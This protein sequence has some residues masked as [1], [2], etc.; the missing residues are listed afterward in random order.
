MSPETMLAEIQAAINA[1]QS[2]RHREALTI[3]L[4]LKDTLADKIGERQRSG[5]F[6]NE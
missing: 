1:I 6:N 3:L 5:G 4:L 2:A